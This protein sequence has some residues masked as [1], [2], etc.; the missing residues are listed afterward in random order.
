MDKDPVR[1]SPKVPGCMKSSEALLDSLAPDEQIK[2]IAMG[3]SPGEISR[4]TT[5]YRMWKK[6]NIKKIQYR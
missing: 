1:A 6:N 3:E 4:R 2:T 5:E